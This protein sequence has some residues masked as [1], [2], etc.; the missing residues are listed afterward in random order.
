M[1]KPILI[2][3]FFVLFLIRYET[4]TAQITTERAYAINWLSELVLENHNTLFSVV[5]TSSDYA[6]PTLH[7]FTGS[8]TTSQGWV[9]K[10]FRLTFASGFKFAFPF[11]NAERTL[12]HLDKA[13]IVAGPHQFIEDRVVEL[14][15]NPGNS[16]RTVQRS[17]LNYVPFF[18]LSFGRIGIGKRSN[19]IRN[20]LFTVQ[21]GGNIFLDSL[22]QS[23]ISTPLK[24]DYQNNISIV[25]LSFQYDFLQAE[26]ITMQLLS[27]LSFSRSRT[28]VTFGSH[29]STVP[30]LVPSN[31]QFYTDTTTLYYIQQINEIPSFTS[32]IHTTYILQLGVRTELNLNLFGLFLQ[33]KLL[34]KLFDNYYGYT[35]LNYYITTGPNIGDRLAALNT[36]TQHEHTSSAVVVPTFLIG[37]RLFRVV[38]LVL[39][40]SFFQ[41]A[42]FVNSAG[43]G[44]SIDIAL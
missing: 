16:L 31:E 12:R 26:W 25:N 37:F 9:L 29:D 36:R 4:L 30:I 6:M 15:R 42:S 32:L 19:P 17:V 2:F 13:I 11:L 35:D 23:L 34:F 24:L 1:K 7:G 10:N 39:E 27:G 5:A 18:S 41:D 33:T 21:Y 28:K 14:S 44:F 38:N 22:K 3:T 8:E 43:A 40:V 20:L